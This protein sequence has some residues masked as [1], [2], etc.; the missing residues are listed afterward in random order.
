VPGPNPLRVSEQLDFVGAALPAPPAR[1]LDVG[2]GEG[3]LAA[4]L[5]ARGYT[6]VGIDPDPDAVAGAVG[7]GV[8]AVETELAS[9]DDLAGFD[10]V[11]FS[12]SLHHMPDQRTAVDR[13]SSLITAAGVVV[14]D[15][16]A[17]DEA[18]SATA[19]LFYGLRDLLVATGVAAL[20]HDHDHER[21][22]PDHEVGQDDP[23]SRWRAQ[24]R[25]DPPL[26]GGAAML[27]ALRGALQVDSVRRGSYLWTYL[28]EIVEDSPRGHHATGALRDLERQ[29]IESGAIRPLGLRVVASRR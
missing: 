3:R 21:H 8:E 10:A 20:D 5:Q 19:T 2:C 17:H 27:T 28:A 13:V 29:L 4:A 12:S 25:H 14:V 11:V 9:F 26:H 7:R 1:V 16:F 23:L 18:D 24:H 15:E 22:P 6:V